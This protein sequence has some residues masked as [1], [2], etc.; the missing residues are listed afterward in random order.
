MKKNLIKTIDL[1]V[2]QF[3][4]L[5]GSI[6]YRYKPENSTG[7]IPGI[8][9]I[10][11]HN[12]LSVYDALRYLGETGEYYYMVEPIEIPDKKHIDNTICLLK[13]AMKA[14]ELDGLTYVD[15][16]SNLKDY[17]HETIISK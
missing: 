16:L 7:W 15:N 12:H 2:G 4:D 8:W 14:N 10:E 11:K 17:L 9:I 1:K 6:V 13:K 5:N 3:A